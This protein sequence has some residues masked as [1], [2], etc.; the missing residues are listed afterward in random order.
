MGEF[1]EK[2]YS[3]GHS[4]RLIRGKTDHVSI[5]AEVVCFTYEDC[6]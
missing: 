4:I 5:P 6:N 3:N 2:C 1:T